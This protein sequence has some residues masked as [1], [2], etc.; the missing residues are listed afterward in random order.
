MIDTKQVLAIIP[1]RG[2]S[3]GVPRK[4]I[5]LLGGK[6]LIEWTVEAAKGSRYIGQ[7]VIST[8]DE[9]I[10]SVAKNAGCELPFMRPEYLATDT[11]SSMDVIAHTIDSLEGSYNW[12]VLLQP[13]SPFRTAQ[14]IDQAFELILKYNA[15]SCVSVVESNKSPEWMF[16]LDDEGRSMSPI[17]EGVPSTRRQDCRTAYLMNGALYICSVKAFEEQKKLVFADTVPYVMSETDS[18]DID[19]LEDFYRAE[20]KLGGSHARA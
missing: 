13:T 14:H 6:P 1:A 5:K 2:G 10:A 17:L 8:D 18:L 11:A 16:W 4:N 9:E 15:S 7:I 3:K 12:L 19:T 20:F